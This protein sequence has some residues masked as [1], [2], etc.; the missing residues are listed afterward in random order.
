MYCNSLHEVLYCYF[1]GQSTMLSQVHSNL[2]GV[3]W[4]SAATKCGQYGLENDQ[5]ILRDI[6]SFS[7]VLIVKDWD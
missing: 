1:P 2:S 3:S 5:H 7:L 4:E 6:S